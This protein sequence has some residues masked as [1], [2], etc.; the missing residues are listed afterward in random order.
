MQ[1]LSIVYHGPKKVKKDT[2]AKTGY[3]F[4]RLEPLLVPYQAALVL[5]QHPTVWME[6]KLLTE[7]LIAESN[8]A[9][10]T[11][12]ETKVKQVLSGQ[13]IDTS[14]LGGNDDGG[15]DLS[16]E[17]ESVTTKAALDKWMEDNDINLEFERD[18]TMTY[19][20]E[21]IINE[22]KRIIEED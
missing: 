7:E 2:V 13:D 1:N 11:A 9:L 10:Q 20:R 5:L 17:L 6:E 14:K 12:E 21:Q 16:D 19:R 18:D 22:V 8:A 15:D 4:K 3:I